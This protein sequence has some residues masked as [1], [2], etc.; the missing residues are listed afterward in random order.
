MARTSHSRRRGW[1]SLWLV[2]WLPVLLALFCG[3][4]VVANLWLARVELENA[5]EA[6]AL[7]SVKEWGDAGGGDTLSA[8]Q[9]GAEFAAANSVRGQPLELATN[10]AGQL[11]SRSGLVRVRLVSAQPPTDCNQ[12]L[13][14]DPGSGHL[15]FGAIDDTD[16]NHVVFNVGLC[17]SCGEAKFGVRAQ[18]MVE[19][20][21][22]NCVFL[23]NLG[24]SQ[25]QA[26][27]TAQYD[28]QTRRV[29][30]VRI[31]EFICPGQ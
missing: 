21:M 13:T 8:R 3:L 29:R 25:I 6:A 4:I 31:D 18:A 12:N 30:L 9:V 14:C 26:K 16:P 5:L 15:I 28:C 19:V 22:L 1:T 7:A 24:P 17:P 23:G 11:A 20:P 10:Y 27:A 2:V